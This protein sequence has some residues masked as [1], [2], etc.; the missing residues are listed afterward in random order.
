MRTE[1]DGVRKGGRRRLFDKDAD[2]ATFEAIIEETLE[3]CPLRICGYC[4]MP[5]HWHFVMWPEGDEDLGVFMQRLSV[6]HVTRW[7]KHRR[8]V[9]EGHLYQ[10]RFKS[11]PVE[12]DDCVPL[13]SG[14]LTCPSSRFKVAFI[15]PREDS[16]AR[17]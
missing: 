12:T 16:R 11:F 5:N 2:Y 3:K 9:G 4:L 6:T 13:A 10:S 8:V 15:A 14:P 17:V 7:Q 1:F